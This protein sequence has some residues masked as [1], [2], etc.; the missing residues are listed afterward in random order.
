MIDVVARRR[1]LGF[2]KH[3]RPVRGVVDRVVLEHDR[4]FLG[5]VPEHLGD[6]TTRFLPTGRSP[7]LLP[8]PDQITLRG[9]PV[10]VEALL[11]AEQRRDRPGGGERPVAESEREHQ[12][13]RLRRDG[14]VVRAEV[15]RRGSVVLAPVAD[16]LLTDPL[17]GV[18][19]PEVRRQQTRPG[20]GDDVQADPDLAEP[21][22]EVL[23]AQV[24][25]LV[26]DVRQREFELFTVRS[27]ER[28]AAV[29]P[30]AGGSL[31]Q[32]L[33]G[34]LQ[35]AVERDCVVR[36]V[37]PPRRVERVL[38]AHT[39][40]RDVLCDELVVVDV[41]QRLTHLLVPELAPPVDALVDA[42][43]AGVGDE[44]VLVEAGVL[45]VRPVTH[46]RRRDSDTVD[47]AGLDRLASRR[48]LVEVLD[49]V[50]VE[51][52]RL[53]EDVRDVVVFGG[54]LAEVVVVR[55]LELVD[56]LLFPPFEVPRTEVPVERRLQ[57]LL[58]FLEPF[59]VLVFDVR[60]SDL[61]RDRDRTAERLVVREERS[62]ARNRRLDRQVVDLVELDRFVVRSDGVQVVVRVAGPVGRED[63]LDRV[64][65]V[66][67]RDLAVAVPPL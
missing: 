52:R 58:V 22:F 45:A 60:L 27:D 13:P 2:P 31:L 25:R 19:G 6:R 36:V 41:R 7:G 12:V 8:E 55:A 10:R 67:D 16:L 44:R 38:N 14:L 49:V 64:D 4:P 1:A 53:T 51:E 59:A 50:L 3:F 65:V 56:G 63:V 29:P 37:R 20:G 47:L 33:A 17:C 43:V 30:V 28:V 66:V 62:R 35:R 48:Q 9:E 61:P 39:A 42:E 32:Q 34:L 57:H 21:L 24:V 40:V 5:E 11:L 15:V 46:L 26:G 23:C 54:D 18:V